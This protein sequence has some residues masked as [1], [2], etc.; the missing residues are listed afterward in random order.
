MNVSGSEPLIIS[1]LNAARH[2]LHWLLAA[3]NAH[4]DPPLLSIPSLSPSPSLSLSHSDLH[5]HK[6]I[7]AAMQ[8]IWMLYLFLHTNSAEAEMHF[9]LF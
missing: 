6:G 5:V 1:A 4:K 8:Q 9:L 2:T 3:S 7:T